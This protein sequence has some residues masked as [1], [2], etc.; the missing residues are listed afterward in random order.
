MTNNGKET[1][2]SV[3]A[4]AVVV[5]GPNSDLNILMIP[6]LQNRLKVMARHPHCYLKRS[7]TC[8]PMTFL[9]N[10][11]SSQDKLVQNM[12]EELKFIRV[13]TKALAESEEVKAI[14]NSLKI[15]G[16]RPKPS[17]WCQMSA[18]SASNQKVLQSAFDQ[19]T[20]AKLHVECCD[21]DYSKALAI[22]KSFVTEL[23]KKFCE[24]SPNKKSANIS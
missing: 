19:V 21:D 12:V 3:T 20:N 16:T 1:T 9:R 22:D 13:L 2:T 18:G 24:G 4:P 5:T 8:S 7:S 6:N 10:I 14:V 11:A 17:L 23:A 15:A